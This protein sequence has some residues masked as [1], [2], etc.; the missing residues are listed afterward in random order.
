[1]NQV[2]ARGHGIVEVDDLPIWYEETGTG[3]PLVLLHGGMATNATWGAQLDGLART[4]RV[5]APERRGHG[6]TADRAGPLTYE[7]MTAE[8]IGFL[9]AMELG[10]VHLLG[11][12]DGGMIGL[13]VASERPDLVRS[14]IVTGSGFSDA[15]Y[16]PGAMEALCGLAPG[17]DELAMFEA[18]YAESSPDGPEHFGAVWGKVR[19]MWAAPFDWSDRLALVSAPT[20]VVVGDDDY[21]TVGHAEAFA[22]GVPDGQLAVLPGTSH[23]APMEKPALFNRMVTD[24]VTQPRAATLMPLRRR[25]P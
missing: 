8:T 3:E 5:L 13:R 17:D 19:A 23:L 4:F 1:M 12:S 20:L 11:W 25:T 16:V 18:L 14:L 22:T 15:G 2:G 10:S 9:E 7:A 24:F 6:H 21:V